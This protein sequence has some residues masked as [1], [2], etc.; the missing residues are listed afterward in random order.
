MKASQGHL[1]Q[2]TPEKWGSFHHCELIYDSEERGE[3]QI[4]CD[5]KNKGRRTYSL[6]CLLR[7]LTARRL[8]IFAVEVRLHH[9][10]KGDKNIFI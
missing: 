2:P 5:R 10:H 6:D 8:K 1:A 9:A 7:W 4:L 3:G